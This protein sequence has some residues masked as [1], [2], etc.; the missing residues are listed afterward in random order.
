[1]LQYQSNSNYDYDFEILK[2]AFFVM[3]TLGFDLPIVI[4]FIMKTIDTLFF[5]PKR[6]LHNN[7]DFLPLW[8]LSFNLHFLC[9]IV[10][11]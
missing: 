1:M 11:I 5:I 7:S 6:N 4:I 8:L 3:Y 9:F 2:E 10:F